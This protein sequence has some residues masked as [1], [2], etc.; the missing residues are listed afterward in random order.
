MFG[1]FFQRKLL[2]NIFEDNEMHFKQF[3]EDFFFKT[4]ILF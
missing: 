2:I 1:V 3:I 4:G